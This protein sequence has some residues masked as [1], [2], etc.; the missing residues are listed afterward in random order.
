MNIQ[1]N[2]D[3]VIGNLISLCQRILNEGLR[4]VAE[5][6]IDS[7]NELRNEVYVV[8]QK[9]QDKEYKAAFV[10]SLRVILKMLN[11]II[12]VINYFTVGIGNAICSLVSNACELCLKYLPECKELENFTRF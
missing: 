4:N 9:F 6:Y 2:K 12:S 11:L 10:A 3:A 1:V 5:G 8:I 7:L